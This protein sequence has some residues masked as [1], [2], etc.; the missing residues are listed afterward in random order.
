LCGE[1]SMLRTSWQ[2]SPKYT[3][4]SNTCILTSANKPSPQP[5]ASWWSHKPEGPVPSWR[6]ST[7]SAYTLP[8]KQLRGITGALVSCSCF[9]CRCTSIL[10]LLHGVSGEKLDRGQNWAH[11]WEPQSRNL[12]GKRKT[13]LWSWG[14][15]AAQW[16]FILQDELYQQTGRSYGL[17]VQ[18]HSTRF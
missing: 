9:H 7:F 10:H 12:T 16:S 2:E 3:E 5:A 15:R 13:V 14:G 1:P 6:T 17:R 8:N 4:C 11:T 18:M